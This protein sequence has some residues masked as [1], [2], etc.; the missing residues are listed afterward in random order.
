[1]KIGKSIK[2]KNIK[3]GFYDKP[4]SSFIWLTTLAKSNKVIYLDNAEDVQKLANWLLMA[5]DKM[6]SNNTEQ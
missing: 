6:D 3:A 2:I 5:A 1:M 4:D